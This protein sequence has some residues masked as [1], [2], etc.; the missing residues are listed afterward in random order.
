MVSPYT[1]S[2]LP[3]PPSHQRLPLPPPSYAG[4]VV[5]SGLVRVAHQMHEAPASDSEPTHLYHHDRE[6]LKASPNLGSSPPAGLF[7]SGKTRVRGEVQPVSVLRGGSGCPQVV[8]RSLNGRFTSA[9]PSRPIRPRSRAL[10]RPPLE[11]LVG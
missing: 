5:Y 11:R 7:Q 4:S 3:R 6:W 8:P 10:T 9:L 1:P 2:C